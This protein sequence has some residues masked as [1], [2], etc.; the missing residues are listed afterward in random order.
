LRQTIAR[1][2]A[3]A[4]ALAPPPPCPLGIAEIDQALGGG[5]AG[6]TLHEIAAC[7]EQHLTA[8][9]G[10]A[11]GVAVR[12]GGKA[13][14]WAA[15]DMALLENGAPYGPGLDQFGLAP[16]RLVTVA[17]AKPADV[18]WTMEE[19]LHCRA[20][21]VVVG[22]LRSG[23]GAVDLVA[24]RRLSLAAAEHGALALLL[25]IAPDPE[26]SA[27]ATRWV[28]EASPHAS[29]GL[30]RYDSA[31]GPPRLAL[32]LMRN[33][34]GPIGSWMVEWSVSDASFTL[35]THSQPVARAPFDR[36]DRARAA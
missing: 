24:S 7:S 30:G 33:R 13:A 19:A 23:A 2:Q 15:E 8:A 31:T 4:V 9:T 27:A 26:A 3:P 5:L 29:P 25:R 14:V 36:P 22:E 10:F 28:V 35:A 34:R 6:G 12:S 1:M 21:G 16:E 20:V 18:L 32:T 17:A 11:L